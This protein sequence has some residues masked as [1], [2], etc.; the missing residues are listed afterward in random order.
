[1]RY[2][3]D[4]LYVR[5]CGISLLFLSIFCKRI[6]RTHLGV[7]Y[8]QTKYIYRE[9]YSCV[10]GFQSLFSLSLSL[11]IYIYINIFVCGFFYGKKN[12]RK[13]IAK[14]LR[15]MHLKL[16]KKKCEACVK[17]REKNKNKARAREREGRNKKLILLK[18]NFQII[19]F[20]SCH[21]LQLILYTLIIII[22]LLL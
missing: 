8:A 14:Q 15:Y 5:I 1:M 16:T 21:G 10:F 2:A 6:H 3:L 19:F 11:Y 7:Y 4:H 20:F 12:R 13:H 22:V 18:I 9:I 17:Q